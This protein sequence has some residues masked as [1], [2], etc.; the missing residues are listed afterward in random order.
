MVRRPNLWFWTSLFRY[1]PVQCFTI[2]PQ[3]RDSTGCGILMIS[4]D[5]HIVMA[6]TDTVRLNGHICCGNPGSVVVILNICA[7]LVRL[8]Q[9]FWQFTGMIMVTSISPMAPSSMPTGQSAN[10]V[11]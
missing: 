9:C 4:H 3:I 7:C 10:P 11:I 6:D 1:L 2:D 8:I 5:L